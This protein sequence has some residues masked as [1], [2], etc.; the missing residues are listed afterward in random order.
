MNGAKTHL[1][2]TKR[3]EI[4]NRTILTIRA[5]M[6]ALWENHQKEIARIEKMSPKQLKQELKRKQHGF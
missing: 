3:M 6:R 5:K 4:P 2:R 1:L